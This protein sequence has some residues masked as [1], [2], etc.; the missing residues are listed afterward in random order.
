M[1]CPR[2]AGADSRVVDSRLTP[3]EDA[4]R[5]R[6]ECERCLYRFTSYERVEVPS[7]LVVKKDGV[8]ERFD[9]DKLRAGIVVALHRRPVAAEAVEEFLRATEAR[10][11]ESNASE[12]RSAELGAW[13]M[14]F[15]RA[16]DTIGYVRF[17]SVYREFADIGWLL[18]EVTAL[19][20]AEGIAAERA[21]EGR[22][23]GVADPDGNP[24]DGART[25][26]GDGRDAAWIAAHPATAVSVSGS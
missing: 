24:H 16:V 25:A 4:I 6:R 8:R 19:A 20:R 1:R 17:A 11:A 12:V 26:A 18:G 10:L 21:A 2:C 9:R 7:I 23:E 14:D 13:A 5:R 22:A 15:L 3:R